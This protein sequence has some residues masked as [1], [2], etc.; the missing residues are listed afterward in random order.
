MIRTIRTS[1]HQLD[2]IP[3]GSV[4]AVITSP[5]YYGLRSYA[6]EQDV[7]WPTVTYRLNEWCEPVTVPPMQCA[8]G[9]E[10]SP[11]A[12]IG[13]LILCLREWRRVLRDDGVCFVNLGDSYSGSANSG[14]T[15][16]N[17][18][19]IPHRLSGMPNKSGNGIKPKDLL[20]IPAMFAIAARADGWWLRSAIVWAKGVSFLPDY[21][22]S[23]MPESVT[24]RPTKAYEMVFLL[25]KSD[26]Y[27]YDAEA[28]KEVSTGQNGAAA[29]FKRVTK[30]HLAP[31]Q[32][33]TQHRDDREPTRDNGTR[34]LRDVWCINPQPYKAA[35]Y[36]VFPPKLVEPMVKASTSERGCCPNCGAPWRRVVERG[37]NPFPGSSHTHEKD[38]EQG[39]T[40]THESGKPAGT[41]MA[42]RW[43]QKQPDTTLGWQPTCTCDAGDPIPCTILDPF[44]GSGTTG[45]VAAS[46]GRAAILC[47]VSGEYLEKHVP[48]RTTVQIGLP[49]L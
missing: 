2:A 37:Y 13:H 48:E 49:Q 15:N 6:G 38:S 28:V 45:R 40:Q 16:K 34:N 7:E 21:A 20:M 23:V 33:A 39:N 14:G 36:A 18:G 26:Q 41:V 19:G 1:A 3:D 29:N 4:Q 25:A 11:V 46:L 27:F 24:D 10:S 31:G 44:A 35:H 5:P 17:D 12:Y 42:Q 32:T 22:G 9:L 47:D 43:Y 8:L 30:E